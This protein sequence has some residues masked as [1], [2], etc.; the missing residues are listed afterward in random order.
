MSGFLPADWPAP[1]G[2]SAGTTPRDGPGVSLPPF[3]RF[4]LGEHCGDAPSAVSANRAALRRMLDLPGEPHWLRQVHGIGVV[5]VE[6]AAE[7]ARSRVQLEPRVHSIHGWLPPEAA[8]RSKLRSTPECT[9]AVEPSL[10]GCRSAQAT[11]T[12][13]PEADAAVS[14]D[15]GV[16][17]AVLSADC[18]PLLFAAVDGTEV[19]AAHAGWRGLAGGVIEATVAAMR[20]SPSALRVWLGPAAG[21]TAYEVGDEVRASFVDLDAA[22]SAAFR[23]TRPGHWLCDLYALARLRLR[24]I[25]VDDVHGGGL[26]TISDRA[27]FYSHRRDQRTGRM[28]SLIWRAG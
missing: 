22:A 13:A 3:D 15:P 4:N 8:Q 16:V 26:C 17:L 10:L 28:A 9:S 5:R 23:P 27:R 2:V 14:S 12:E 20:T 21:P 25:G 1:P 6:G 11:G 7:P 24:R 18:L 19:G